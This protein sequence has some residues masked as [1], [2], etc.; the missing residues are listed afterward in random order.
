MK[1]I[2]LALLLLASCAATARPQEQPP[3]LLIRAAH[4][5][6]AKHFFAR[7]NV[8][9]RTFGYLIDEK[10]YPR[11]KE[12]YVVTYAAP[13]RSNGSAFAIVL[14]QWDDHQIFN[15]QN[16]ASFVLS[17]RDIYGVSFVN[18]PLGGDWTQGRLASA[19]E[20]IEKQAR[21]TIPV[22]DF[23]VADA[24]TS[25]ESYTDPQPKPATK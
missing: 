21:F 3:L 7:S 6:A 1:K 17:K 4:C 2:A 15:I 12:M 22:R 14:T 24:S 9:E 11:Q 16:N 5:L 13:A 20:R 18:P 10:S 25:C 8:T 23:A 19:I